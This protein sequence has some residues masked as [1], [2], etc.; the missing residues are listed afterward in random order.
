MSASSNASPK[1][2]KPVRVGSSRQMSRNDA[3]PKVPELPLLTCHR[4]SLTSRTRAARPGLPTTHIIG[5]PLKGLTHPV[6]AEGAA[7][8]AHLP[9]GL[10]RLIVRLEWLDSFL[11]A[12]SR[13]FMPH[14]SFKDMVRPIDN[15]VL[16]P[17]VLAQ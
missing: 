5:G 12:I 3:D 6:N 8:L 2:S 13:G 16:G 1:A 14:P 9:S 15:S 10:K 17:E 11:Q 4:L 7:H